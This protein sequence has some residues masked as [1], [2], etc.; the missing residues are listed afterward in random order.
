[1]FGVQTPACVP[2]ILITVSADD[3][4][5]TVTIL[6]YCIPLRGIKPDNRKLYIVR[7]LDSRRNGK[8]SILL[9]IVMSFFK[10]KASSAIV[11]TS[12]TQYKS[13]CYLIILITK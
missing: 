1:M 3:R 11:S 13:M 6:Y 8:Y 12:T 4:D 7:S 10:E 9:Y 5:D 2:S